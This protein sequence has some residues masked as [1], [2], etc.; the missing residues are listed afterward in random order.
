M[1]EGGQ[2][3]FYAPFNATVSAIILASGAMPAVSASITLDVWSSPG[4]YANSTLVA[5]TAAGNWGSALAA[6][7]TF[8][9]AN[10]FYR[11]RS[12]LLDMSVATSL[13]GLNLSV[14]F[15]VSIGTQAYVP[16]A[17]PGVLTVTPTVARALLPLTTSSEFANSTLPWYA[18]RTLSAAMLCTNVTQVL[19]KSGTVLAGRVSPNVVNPFSVTSAYIGAL[20]PAEKAWLPLETGLYTYCP[21]SSDLANFW[22]Y[23]LATGGVAQNTGAGIGSFVSPASAP[24]YRLDNDAMVNVAFV[25]AGPA[26][27]ALA[28]TVSWHIEFRT[29]SALFQ[30]ALSGMTLETL[31]Q[32]QLVLATAGFFFDNPDHRAIIAKVVQ[33]ANK[34]APLAL[35]AA[36]MYSPLATTA[37]TKGYNM[38]ARA[39]N[40]ARKVP[41][42][43][44]PARMPTTT[45]SASGI[46][47]RKA[48]KT[49]KAV[50]KR[51]K[52]TRK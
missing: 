27:E 46:V 18:T 28:I 23:S 52:K 50:V 20:H 48:K 10:T 47:P 51:P 40:A 1:D 21:P 15:V 30:V 5:N 26:D 29:S 13:F 2:P 12:M 6:S 17:S 7:N 45:A 39:Y 19:N 9:G 24:L 35:G 37:A 16:A 49:K 14:V 31:H 34:L 11:P 33:A 25:T 41:V 4:E 42:P 43:S 22:D 3:W 38:V 8:T 36:K 32:A 44:G